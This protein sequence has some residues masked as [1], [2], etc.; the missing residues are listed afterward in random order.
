[1]KK[2]FRTS[3][4]VLVI[5]LM[6]IGVGQPRGSAAMDKPPF[7]PTCLALCQLLNLECFFSTLKKS[8]Q[9][10]CTAQYRNCIAHCK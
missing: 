5:A 1:M 4:F 10:K 3:V 7:D 2:Y 6:L 9:H 8:D